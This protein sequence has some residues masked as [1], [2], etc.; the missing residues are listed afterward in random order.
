MRKCI[1]TPQ[2][3]RRNSFSSTAIALV[4]VVAGIQTFAGAAPVAITGTAAKAAQH[5]SSEL[6]TCIA[7]D[8][9]RQLA[10]CRSMSIVQFF[11][12]S[13]YNR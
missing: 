13:P 4:S 2:R 6:F 11:A 10:R 3:I 1:S 8:Q 9:H 12:Q 7:R 5:A